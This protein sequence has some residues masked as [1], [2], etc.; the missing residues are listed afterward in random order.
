MHYVLT[1]LTGNTYKIC[2][3]RAKTILLLISYT[4]LVLHLSIEIYKQKEHNYIILIISTLQSKHLAH[5]LLELHVQRTTQPKSKPNQNRRVH[6]PTHDEPVHE[7]THVSAQSIWLDGLFQFLL[8]PWQ[9]F[10]E[11]THKLMQHCGISHT[12]VIWISTTKPLAWP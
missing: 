9:P 1:D 8:L 4:K 3:A 12:A 10:T 7:G 6:T 11:T 5:S 2:W